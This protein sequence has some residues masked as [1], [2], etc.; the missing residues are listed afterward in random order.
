MVFLIKW[1]KFVQS[2]LLI[3]V[4]VSN[5]TFGVKAFLL[6][7]DVEKQLLKSAANGIVFSGDGPSFTETLNTYYGFTL[8]FLSLAIVLSFFWKDLMIRMLGLIPLVL[9]APFIFVSMRYKHGLLI[10]TSQLQ[11][12]PWLDD[13]YFADICCL[14]AILIVLI[15][16]IYEA[17]HLAKSKST[18]GLVGQ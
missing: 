7:S 1:N 15:L 13:A 16:G 9:S 12:V 3:G 14:T 2:L 4:F 10:E 18:A 6:W 11:L 17:L 8:F 5:L